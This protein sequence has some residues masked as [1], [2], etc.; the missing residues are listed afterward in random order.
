MLISHVVTNSASIRLQA[1]AAELPWGILAAVLCIRD[2]YGW[3]NKTLQMESYPLAVYFVRNVA[4]KRRHCKIKKSLECQKFL[5][6][7]V[8]NYSGL[9]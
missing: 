2:I 7:N 8:G 3:K 1:E 4:E 9:S 6:G 5:E